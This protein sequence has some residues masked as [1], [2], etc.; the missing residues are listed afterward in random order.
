MAF[1][2][3]SEIGLLILNELNCEDSVKHPKF[4]LNYFLL[5]KTMELAD[6]ICAS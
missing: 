6:G 2:G 4:F 1:I 5:K 3:V